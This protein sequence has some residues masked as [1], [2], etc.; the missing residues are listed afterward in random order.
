MQKNKAAALFILFMLS[1]LFPELKAQE[2]VPAAGSNASGTTGTVSYTVGQIEYTLNSA[3]TG[4]M[5]QGI[6]LP[7]EISLITSVSPAPGFSLTCIAYP[8]PAAGVLNLKVGNMVSESLSYTL[9]DSQ[10]KLLETKQVIAAESLVM[11]SQYPDAIYFLTIYNLG[12]KIE[13]FRI[14][15]N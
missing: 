5:A 2:T 10:G 13:T 11:L 6:Q 14:I 3:T 15:H 4:S 12:K 1:V 8:N 9:I 7:Y